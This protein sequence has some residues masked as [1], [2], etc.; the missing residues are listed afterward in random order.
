M[1]PGTGML[2]YAEGMG[3]PAPAKGSLRND[4]GNFHVTESGTVSVG[5]TFWGGWNNNKK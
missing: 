1:P 5:G 4:I 2:E 3:T